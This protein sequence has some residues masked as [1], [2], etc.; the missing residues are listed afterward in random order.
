MH[1]SKGCV[2]VHPQ[3]FLGE[4]GSGGG[5]GG[6]GSGGGGGGGGGYNEGVGGRGYNGGV[7]GGGG[8]Y[9][10]GVEGGGGGYNEGGLPL[11]SGDGGR[12]E[13][14]LEYLEGRWPPLVLDHIYDPL[15]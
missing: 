8:G 11:P 4:K 5:G 9:N 2:V 3:A 1:V 12:V 7:E 15:F 14:G 6:G 13:E 10:G